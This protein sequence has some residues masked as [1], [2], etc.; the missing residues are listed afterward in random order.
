MAG[1]S[2]GSAG[3]W[4]V[5]A[6][7]SVVQA[8]AE[9]ESYFCPANANVS[10]TIYTISTH[11][12]SRDD[13]GGTTFNKKSIWKESTA[14]WQLRWGP[15]LSVCLAIFFLNGWITILGRLCACMHAHT[16]RAAFYD[17]WNEYSNG[18]I[19]MH[20]TLYIQQ[21]HTLCTHNKELTDSLKVGQVNYSSPVIVKYF[22]SVW[23]Y[24]CESSRGE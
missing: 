16:H 1:A 14:D 18:L 12:W 19:C 2:G 10:V 3:S 8:D 9:V 13:G 24:T 6:W 7:A 20:N 17:Y 23:N 5:V 22:V 21:H 4:T 15:S 11:K